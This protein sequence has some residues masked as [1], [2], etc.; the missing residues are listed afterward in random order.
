M[1]VLLQLLLVSEDGELGVVGTDS[2]IDIVSFLPRIRLSLLLAPLTLAEP[3]PSLSA[4][5][6]HS[7]PT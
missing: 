5:H 1:L 7:T 4:L 6:Y 3:T 2:Q